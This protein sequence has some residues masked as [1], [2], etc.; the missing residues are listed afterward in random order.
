MSYRC[1]KCFRPE[2]CCLC[3]FTKEFDPEIKFI[4]LMHPK[5]ARKQR[6]GTGRLCKISMK[7]CEILEGIDFSE[8]KRLNELI[9]DKK[10][11]PVIMYPDIDAINAESEV[12]K[13]ELNKKKKKLLA[14]LI[15]GTWFCAKKIIQKNQ[16]LMNLPKMSFCNENKSIF[17][18][19]KEPSEECVSTLE[20]CYYLIKELQKNLLISDSINPEPLMNVFKQMIKFQLQAENERVQGLRPNVHASNFKYK[21]IKE[22]PDFKIERFKK[23]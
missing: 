9:N 17:T 16:N 5:E 18:F 15:D 13:D 19:K 10:Y 8:N 11:F 21:K 14:I 4:L 7:D 12:L 6:T 20:T 3:E 1:S 22:I 23:N 2:D